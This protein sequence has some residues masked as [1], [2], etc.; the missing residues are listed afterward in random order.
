MHPDWVSRGGLASRRDIA[1][2]KLDRPVKGVEPVSL[3]ARDDEAGKVVTFV[4]RGWAGTGLTAPVR[5]LER[6]LRGATNKVDEVNGTS[7]RMVFDAPPGGTD[8]EG[9]S[10]PGDSGGPALLEIGRAR[11]GR[12]LRSLQFGAGSRNREVQHSIPLGII[13]EGQDAGASGTRQPRADRTTRHTRTLRLFAQ[14]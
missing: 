5:D 10:G 7:I 6:D 4:G 12:L 3:Y 1:L 9:I 11:G 13:L 8:F 2:L 14:G